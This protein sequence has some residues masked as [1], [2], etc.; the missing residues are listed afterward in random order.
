MARRSRVLYRPGSSTG[1]PI[2][3]M[4]RPS[5]PAPTGT[6]SDRRCRVPPGRA[7]AL[8]WC[9][10]RWCAPFLAEL[11]RDFEHEAIALVG[12]LQRVEDRRQ[13]AFEMDVDDGADDLGDVS[14]IRHHVPL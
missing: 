3:L 11:L 10:S 8:R 9:P 6:E 12:G 7:P 2:T 5:S 14:D 13:L 4:M 1:S